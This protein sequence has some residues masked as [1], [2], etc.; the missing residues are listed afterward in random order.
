MPSPDP[1]AAVPRF[2][3]SVPFQVNRVRAAAIYCA[4]G[5]YGDQFDEFL[6]RELG[7]P[8]YDR[9]ALP[10]GA[11]AFAG[12]IES[13]RSE[14]ALISE[15]EFLIVSHD[16]DRVVLIAHEGCGYYLKKLHTPP[17]ALLAAQERDL[18]RAAGVLLRIRPTLAVSAHLASV[19]N[20]SVV[21][22]DVAI[23]PAP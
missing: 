4:D 18:S 11:G 14:D 23:T 9:V 20:N 13:M 1:I 15:I 16:L 17:G 7:L 2:R 21:F 10:G 19:R 12:H 5:R 8:C 22:S 6:H 3:A